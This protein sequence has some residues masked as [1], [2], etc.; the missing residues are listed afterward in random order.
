MTLAVDALKAIHGAIKA[1]PSAFIS[2][3]AYDKTAESYNSATATNTFTERS[4][5][6]YSVVERFKADEIDGKIVKNFDVKLIVLPKKLS[7]FDFELSSV[8]RIVANNQ[9]YSIVASIPQYVGN[10]IVSYLLHVRPQGAN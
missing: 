10:V 9:N 2:S 3:I 8:D 7:G 6:V 1:A 5:E 4:M